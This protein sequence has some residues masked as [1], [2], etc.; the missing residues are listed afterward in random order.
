[1]Q[2]S[3]LVCIKRVKGKGRGVFARKY[4]AAGS[5]IEKVPVI[6][7]PYKAF[8]GGE[9]NPYRRKFF[10]MWGKDTAAIVL[11][12][13]S[14]YNHSFMPNA[15]YEHG[16]QVMTFRAL[17]DILAG[18]EITINYNYFPEDRTPVGFEVV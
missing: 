7:V 13:G 2:H 4:I 1:M 6:P 11:G 9:P 18:E 14:L 8:V 15:R 16:P 17:R 10:F 3:D 5:V 12:Y